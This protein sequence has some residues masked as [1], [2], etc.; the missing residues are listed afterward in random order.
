MT[1]TTFKPTREIEPAILSGSKVWLNHE[2]DLPTDASTFSEFKTGFDLKQMTNEKRVREL[3]HGR[4]VSKKLIERL[5][6]KDPGWLPIGEKGKPVL[7]QNILAS[8]SHSGPWI[9]VWAG[10]RPEHTKAIGIDL[11]TWIPEREA[12]LLDEGFRRRSFVFPKMLLALS[13]KE[14]I[15]IVFSILEAIQKILG[16]A[17]E[18]FIAISKLELQVDP[19]LRTWSA[20]SCPNLSISGIYETTEDFALAYGSALPHTQPHLN[21]N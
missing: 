13:K 11:Q 10:T 18:P 16:N 6:G 19:S 7:P 12:A 4:F 8:F 9:A 17:N 2:R 14:R 5:T 3:F 1:E 20:Q 21:L 15:T